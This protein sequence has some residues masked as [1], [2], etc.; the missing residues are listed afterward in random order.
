VTFY[1]G[2]KFFVLEEKDSQKS[3]KYLRKNLENSLILEIITFSIFHNFRWLNIDHK[4]RTKYNVEG[5]GK[6]KNSTEEKQKL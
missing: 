4:F 3:V 5:D 2:K 1:D 6:A